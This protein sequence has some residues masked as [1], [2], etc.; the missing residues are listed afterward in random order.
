MRQ[1]T[2][3]VMVRGNDYQKIKALHCTSLDYV[4]PWVQIPRTTEEE[5]KKRPSWDW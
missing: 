3:R 4:R 2:L 1:S 5:S